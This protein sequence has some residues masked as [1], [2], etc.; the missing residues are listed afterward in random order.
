VSDL[1][2][3]VAFRQKSIAH[4]ERFLA[5]DPPQGQP[6]ADSPPVTLRSFDAVGEGAALCMTRGQRLKF[7]DELVRYMDACDTEQRSEMSG[8]APTIEQYLPCRM[9]TSA[10]GA[11]VAILEYV[12]LPT[13]MF[14]QY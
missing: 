14:Q 2:A 4:F 13:D 12:I 5:D 3:S 8:V 9:G 1:E 7:L 11:V 6:N 10:A